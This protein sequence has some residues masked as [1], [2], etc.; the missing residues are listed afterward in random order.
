MTPGGSPL[1]G[2]CRRTHRPE[3]PH[4][5]PQ[6]GAQ[7]TPR[8]PGLFL[9][10]LYW[11]ARTEPRPLWFLTQAPAKLLSRPGWARIYSAPTS[12]SA[13]GVRHCARPWAWTSCNPGKVHSLPGKS[14]WVGD[15]GS[16]HP[17]AH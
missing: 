10:P 11:G 16:P 15:E 5:L 3:G 14:P 8:Q 9:L 13:S 6:S 7:T 4:S 12:A 1:P 2:G 17:L